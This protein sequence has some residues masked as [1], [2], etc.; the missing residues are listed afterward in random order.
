MARQFAL[1][2]IPE[3]KF[4]VIYDI[5]FTGDEGLFNLSDP[6]FTAFDEG[7]VLIQDG[8]EYKIEAVN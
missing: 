7:E 2:E 1:F 3:D 8:F 5:K 6:C 4:A